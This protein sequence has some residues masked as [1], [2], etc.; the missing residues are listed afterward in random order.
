M[1]SVMERFYFF[2]ERFPFGHGGEVKPRYWAG[3]TPMPGR[4]PTSA[5]EKRSPCGQNMKYGQPHFAPR[6]AAQDG[7]RKGAVGCVQ[8]AKRLALS[9]KHARARI[10]LCY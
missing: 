3:Q 9:R 4:S 8:A 7:A 1:L 5:G 2:M 10:N 6:F